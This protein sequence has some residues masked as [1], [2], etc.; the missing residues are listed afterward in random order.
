MAA[1]SL[2]VALKE[3]GELEEALQLGIESL[4]LARRAFG[5]EDEYTLSAMSI[6]ASVHGTMKDFMRRR[7]MYR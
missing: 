1:I 4:P 7:Y 5:D 3:S 2:T 6:L